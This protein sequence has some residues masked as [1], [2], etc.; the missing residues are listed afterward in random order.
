MNF[1]TALN[2][3]K[4]P[5]IM[6]ITLVVVFAMALIWRGISA[7]LS[8]NTSAPWLQVVISS[9]NLLNTP[10]V[11][12]VVLVLGMIFDVY[13]KIYGLAPDGANQI[14]GA[15]LGLLTSQGVNAANHAI[16][17]LANRQPKPPADPPAAKE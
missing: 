11:A 7:R 3:L 2:S 14:I 5:W 9:I 8:D 16:D 12:L 10:W 15:G 13:S 6:L 4:L 17:Q 1:V